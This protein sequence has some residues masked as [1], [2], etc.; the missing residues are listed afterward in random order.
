[1]QRGFIE[2]IPDMHCELIM[3]F[4]QYSCRMSCKQQPLIQRLRR[5]LHKRKQFEGY[6][7]EEATAIF[8]D[9]AEYYINGL[10]TREYFSALADELLLTFTQ[11]KERRPTSEFLNTLL[12]ASTISSFPSPYERIYHQ[13]VLERFISIR[14]EVKNYANR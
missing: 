11:N 12:T 4:L 14:R 13:K 5:V 1:M 7:L 2:Y 3:G 10:I 8:C 9:Y 6:S